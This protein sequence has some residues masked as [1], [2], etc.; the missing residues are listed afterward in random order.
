M[1]FKAWEDVAESAKRCDVAAKVLTP[2]ESHKVSNEIV[3]HFQLEISG[4]NLEIGVNS[5]SIPLEPYERFI[6][7]FLNKSPIHILF[8][9]PSHKNPVVYLE[10]ACEFSPVMWDSY[11]HQYFVADAEKTY[12]FAV[13]PYCIEVTGSAIDCIPTCLFSPSLK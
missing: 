1:G 4:R 13:N 3:S 11:V 5:K 12:L 8:D 6:S 7:F 2:D 9:Y 10:K